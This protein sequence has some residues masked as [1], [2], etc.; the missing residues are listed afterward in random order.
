MDNLYKLYSRNPTQAPEALQAATA[1]P[2]LLDASRNFQPIQTHLA[3]LSEASGRRTRATVHHDSNRTP[4]LGEARSQ[5]LTIAT[6]RM[7]S[8][9]SYL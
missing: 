9:T 1:C 7:G 2:A 8:K 3:L 6:C 5:S 4:V